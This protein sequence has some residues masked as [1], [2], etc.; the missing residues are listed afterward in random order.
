[1]TIIFWIL[2]CFVII[3]VIITVG[4]LILEILWKGKGDKNETNNTT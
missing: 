4:G 2:I 1:M 3:F